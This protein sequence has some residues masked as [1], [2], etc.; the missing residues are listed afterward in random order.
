[1]DPK[2]QG[3]QT[4]V[5]S[6]MSFPGILMNIFYSFYMLLQKVMNDQ[7]LTADQRILY[8]IGII[9]GFAIISFV[10]L[11][12][13]LFILRWVFRGIARLFDHIAGALSDPGSLLYIAALSIIKSTPWYF[14]V[15]LVI[16]LFSGCLAIIGGGLWVESFK[17]VLGATVG[18]LIGVV[19]T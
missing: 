19:K 6:T 15:L 1:M 16:L 9:I 3:M 10:T 18:S 11:W 13:I 17:Y 7:S 5:N 12:F 4:I 8:R 14:N 2:T